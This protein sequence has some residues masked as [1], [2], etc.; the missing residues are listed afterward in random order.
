MSRRRGFHNAPEPE[1]FRGEPTRGSEW[2]K[3]EC[4]R[5]QGYF[6]SLHSKLSKALEPAGFISDNLE[7]SEYSADNYE[8][9]RETLRRT[10]RILRSYGLEI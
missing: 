4:I 1:F 5:M 8:A 6:L 7:E 3:G 2:N 10:V 9:A